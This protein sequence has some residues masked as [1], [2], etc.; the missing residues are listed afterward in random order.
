MPRHHHHM[1]A[2]PTIQTPPPRLTQRLV[3]N[4]SERRDRGA[5][6]VIRITEM[7]QALHCLQLAENEHITNLQRQGI[8]GLRYNTVRHQ[9][10]TGRVSYGARLIGWVI[11]EELWAAIRG[12]VLVS[13]PQIEATAEVAR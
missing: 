7:E 10:L 6:I 3:F 8:K 4:P 11:D 13:A 1:T 9:Q 5:S 2:T 12:T